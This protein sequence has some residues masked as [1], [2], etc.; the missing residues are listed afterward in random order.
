MPDGTQRLEFARGPFGRHTYMVDLDAQ[1]RVANVEQVLD[2]R[3]FARVTPA[4]RATT[5]CARSAARRA[6][7]HDARRPDLVVALREQ[8]LPVVAG[9]VRCAGCGH[10]GW[11]RARARL[12][13]P[14]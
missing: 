11:L 12:R 3:H 5:C 13:R 6:R 4:R 7:G 14:Q 10:R 8:R 9:A 1:G 2:A